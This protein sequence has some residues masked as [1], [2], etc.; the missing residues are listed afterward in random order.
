MRQG[1]KHYCLMSTEFQFDE[2]F[3]EM[4][5]GDCCTTIRKYLIMP[6]NCILNVL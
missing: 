4:D 5:S 3:L 2:K 6:L 1:M